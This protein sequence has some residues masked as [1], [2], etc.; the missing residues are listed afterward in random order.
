V[1]FDGFGPV[2]FDGYILFINNEKN[3]LY[4]IILI[5]ESRPNR[6]ENKNCQKRDSL[7]K[8]VKYILL[9]LCIL[10]AIGLSVLM[11]R[12]ITGKDASNPDVTTTS[13]SQGG[14]SSYDYF[15]PTSSS[16]YAPQHKYSR[17]K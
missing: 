16:S 3:I 4:I 13:S 11:Y 7:C 6:N 8:A 5:M 1:D 17:H 2:D 15:S 9:I 14:G 10:I 12:N